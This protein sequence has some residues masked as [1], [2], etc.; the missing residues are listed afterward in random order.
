MRFAEDHFH[1]LAGVVFIS[2]PCAKALDVQLV[3]REA[4]G[5]TA[6]EARVAELLCA[7]NSPG[8][9]ADECCVS[10]EAPRYHLKNVYQKLRVG[11]QSELVGLVM[12]LASSLSVN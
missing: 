4:Y 2:D 11:R 12:K 9:I 1:E 10:V 6:A 3:L 8:E 7:G 5:L